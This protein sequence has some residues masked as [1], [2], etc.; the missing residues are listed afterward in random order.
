MPKYIYCISETVD[1]SGVSTITGVENAPLEIVDMDGLFCVV[2]ETEVREQP[3]TREAAFAHEKVLE[4]VMEQSAIIP[5]AFGHVVSSVDEVK[6]TLLEPHRDALVA[7]LDF[8]R[9]KIE[10]NLKAFW[11]DLPAVFADIANENEEIQRIKQKKNIRR[12]DQIRAGEIAAKAI[13]AKRA[14]FHQ[15][16]KDQFADLLVQEKQSKLFGDQMIVNLAVL[17][18]QEKLDIFDA[19]VEQYADERGKTV[20]VKYTGPVPPFNFVEMKISA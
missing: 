11:L 7:Q 8:L 6:S 20:K 12:E 14:A 16:I 4:G 19:R 18:E 2:S 9:D 1:P 3:L 13:E 5:L 15:A 17:I 10:L